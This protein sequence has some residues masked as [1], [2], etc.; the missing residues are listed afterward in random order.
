MTVIRIDNG[1]NRGEFRSCVIASADLRILFYTIEMIELHEL[2]LVRALHLLQGALLLHR[3][4][5]RLF[6]S[7]ASLEVWPILRRG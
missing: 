7:R 4:S 1:Q 6:S 2:N 5:Q 3:A